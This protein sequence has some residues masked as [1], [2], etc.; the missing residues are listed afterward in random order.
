MSIVG[1]QYL[2]IHDHIR[3]V[4]IF[5]YDPKA[6][7][8]HACILHALVIYDK[9]KMGQVYIHLICKEIEVK[10]LDHHPLCPMQ[11]LMNAVA[12]DEV[13]KFLAPILSETMHAIQIM[14]PFIAN[15]AIIITWNISRLTC[16]IGVRKTTQKEYQDQ[17]ILKTELMAEA[18]LWDLPSSEFSRQE[19]IMLDYRG[20]FVVST[21][22]ARRQLFFNSI[23]SCAYDAADVMDDDNMVTALKSFII[24]SLWVT[25]VDTE[26]VPALDHLVLKKCDFSPKKHLIWFIIPHSMVFAQCFTHPQ[27]GSSRLV[28]INW[29]T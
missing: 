5:G 28:T 23:T 7:S 24:T 29:G 11:Y 2:V 4:N 18:K 6:V 27:H 8:K 13:P 14:D 22:P 9:S 20:W 17:Y 25:Q 16:Y 10:G 26:K 12:I 3:P 19:Q 15:L 1:D 21:T